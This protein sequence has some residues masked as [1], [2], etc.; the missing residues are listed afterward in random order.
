LTA[1]RSWLNFRDCGRLTGELQHG[2]L[3]NIQNVRSKHLIAWAALPSGDSE[4]SE[5]PQPLLDLSARR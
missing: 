3:L 1:H 4:H 5:E 2:P